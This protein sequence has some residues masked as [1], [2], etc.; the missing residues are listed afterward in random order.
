[1]RIALNIVG[2]FLVLTGVIWFLQGINVLLGSPMSGHVQWSVWGTFA[3]VI[4]IGVLVSVNRRRPPP[5]ATSRTP[6]Q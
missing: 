2:L 3:A 1:M 4:G 5:S 6:R